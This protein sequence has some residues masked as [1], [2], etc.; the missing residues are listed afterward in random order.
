MDA[1]L[2]NHIN[3]IEDMLFYYEVIESI[4][5][6]ELNTDTKVYNLVIDIIDFKMRELLGEEV[7]NEYCEATP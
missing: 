3:T 1:K 2:V 7:Y 5:F 4:P 6:H